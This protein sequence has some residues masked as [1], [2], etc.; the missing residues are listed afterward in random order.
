MFSHTTNRLHHFS[1][2][3]THINYLTTDARALAHLLIHHTASTLLPSFYRFL[4]AQTTPAQL[5]AAREYNA[6]LEGL[7]KLFERVEAEVG[8]SKA[9][10][11]A[12]GLWG[13]SEEEGEGEIGLIDAMAGPCSLYL[14]RSLIFPSTL[15][16]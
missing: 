8:E 3:L 16:Q 14:L 1:L 5:E 7:V 9:A 6:A 2:Y 4:Q 13:A 12:L 15:T 11:K 10:R